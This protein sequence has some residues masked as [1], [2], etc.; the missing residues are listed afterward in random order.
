MSS[1]LQY[2]QLKF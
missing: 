2:Q 1:K